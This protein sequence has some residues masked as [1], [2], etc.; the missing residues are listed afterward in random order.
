MQEVRSP[1]RK[2]PEVFRQNGQEVPG[3]RRPG[4]TDDLRSRGA[5]QGHW[6]VR[7]R[8]RQEILFAR[9]LGQRRLLLERQERRQIQVG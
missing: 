4:R 7:H 1:L 5:V 9:I 2:N 6:L 3:M 8:L